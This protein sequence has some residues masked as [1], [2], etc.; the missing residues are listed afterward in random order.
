[1]SIKKYLI[2][3]FGSIFIVSLLMAAITIRTANSLQTENKRVVYAQEQ[4]RLLKNIKSTTNRMLKEV[5]DYIIL[6]SFDEFNEFQNARKS[7]IKTLNNLQTIS[8]GELQ[9][10]T[11]NR[12]SEF[13][14]EKKEI[15]VSRQIR[16]QINL[17]IKNAS[18]VIT[19]AQNGNLKKAAQILE[20]EIEP[21]HDDKLH[22]IITMQ[23]KDEQAEI[24][25]VYSSLS[26]TFKTFQI[27]LIASIVL[28][29]A[30]VC[31]AT[32][33][34]WRSIYRPITELVHSMNQIGKGDYSVEIPPNDGEVGLIAKSLQQ[35]AHDLEEKQSQLLQSAKLTSIGQLSAGI[36]ND[37]DRPLSNIRHNAQI[38]R[39]EIS[40]LENSYGLKDSIDLIENDAS[41]IR[42]TINHLKK[43]SRQTDFTKKPLNV[44]EVI[45]SSFTLLN[46]QLKSH[47][48]K[49]LTDLQKDLPLFMGNENDLEQVFLNIMT[50]ACNAI[51]ARYDLSKGQIYIS[52]H[53]NTDEK[54]IEICFKDTGT[55]IS[56]AEQPFIF[57]PF[58]S[59]R[60]K[61]SHSGLGLS[62]A[63]GI[64]AQHGGT[65]TLKDTSMEGTVFEIKLPVS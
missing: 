8:E 22:D 51:I 35:M 4:L 21:L 9:Y 65:I 25:S 1:M 24:D 54:L 55:G 30:T 27:Q 57:D 11:R 56:P 44:N 50:N 62:I 39:R 6:Q 58:F 26:E 18:K 23:I 31:F 16:Q 38:M 45:N 64:I 15:L 59:T 53:F 37:M 49:L 13:K 29:L 32:V 40:I 3:A 28:L 61:N 19:V 41:Q 17:I 7:L 52:T 12:Y 60:D 43:F 5:S 48:I 2:I 63:Y 34:A 47:N 33:L 42:I 46:Q 36:A 14:E 10:I 20:E